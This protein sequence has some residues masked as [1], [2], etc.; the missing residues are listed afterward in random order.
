MISPQGY[1]APND[2]CATG[3]IHSGFLGRYPIGSA[4]TRGDNAAFLIA[5]LP[6][7]ATTGLCPRQAWSTIVGYP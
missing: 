7:T 2:N 3:R 1:T 5:Q 6:D 4:M